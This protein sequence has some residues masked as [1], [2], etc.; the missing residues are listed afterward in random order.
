MKLHLVFRRKWWFGLYRPWERH[1][2]LRRKEDEADRGSFLQT[3]GVHR[4]CLVRSAGKQKHV[5]DLLRSGFQQS[6]STFSNKSSRGTIYPSARTLLEGVKPYFQEHLSP[7]V[8][9]QWS[10]WSYLKPF[11]YCYDTTPALDVHLL[12]F[13]TSRH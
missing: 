9:P 5:L 3:V 4:P 1:D 11:E 12:A 2:L 7:L 8:L 10:P 13:G 6:W